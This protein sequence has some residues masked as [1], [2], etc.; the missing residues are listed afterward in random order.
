MG[1]DLLREHFWALA[2][3]SGGKCLTRNVAPHPCIVAHAC[4]T[5]KDLG[6]K[7]GGN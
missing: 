5:R 3:Q 6:D 7:P 4:A 1:I 2:I